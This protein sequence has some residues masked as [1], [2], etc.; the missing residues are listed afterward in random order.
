MIA[1]M[2]VAL[3]LAFFPPV[4][5]WLATRPAGEP[6]TAMKQQAPGA[7]PLP[8]AAPV[9]APEN[10]EWAG[11]GQVMHQNGASL[12]GG[13]W[14]FTVRRGRAFEALWRSGRRYRTLFAGVIDDSGTITFHAQESLE[15]AAKPREAI[16]GTGEIG[17]KRM[18][19]VIEEPDM[20]STV[21]VD[22][23]LLPDGG[24]GFDFQSRWK[25]HHQSSGWTGFRTIEDESKLIDFNG[26]RGTWM[27]D[28]GLFRVFF[29]SGG[30]E[31]LIIDPDNPNQLIGANERLSV[32]WIR[33]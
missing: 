20:S 2:V 29:G 22:F 15:P 18:S 14:T 16:K 3:A 4:N 32:T 30:W 25:C 31:W 7:E 19:V 10:S 17:K 21:R 12:V 24:K 11:T 8:P 9:L 26:V 5:W 6:K 27:R 23:K 33:Q 13:T 1:A 28:G